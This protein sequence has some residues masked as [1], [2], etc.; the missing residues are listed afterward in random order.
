MEV[1]L[2]VVVLLKV[3]RLLLCVTCDSNI[4]IHGNVVGG[5]ERSKEG[6]PLKCAGRGRHY[7]WFSLW[8]E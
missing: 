7:V 4:V 8:G 5:G 3:V 6:E 1:L 2:R